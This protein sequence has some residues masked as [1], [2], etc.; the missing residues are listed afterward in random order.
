MP[1]EKGLKDSVLI[2]KTG[3]KGGFISPTREAKSY[4]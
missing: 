1:K 3:K 4:V 2:L